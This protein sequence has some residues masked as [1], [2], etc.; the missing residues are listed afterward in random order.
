[1]IGRLA[2]ILRKTTHG[3]TACDTLF[4]LTFARYSLVTPLPGLSPV[5]V[6]LCYTVVRINSNGFRKV[7]DGSIHL[8]LSKQ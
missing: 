2:V 3:I 4:R 6:F 5:Q 8:P 7:V 1:M